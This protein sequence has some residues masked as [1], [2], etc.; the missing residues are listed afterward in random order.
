MTKDFRVLLYYKYEHIEDPE[1]F[2]KEHLEFSKSIGLRGRVLVSNEGING[3]VSGTVEQTEKYKEYLHSLPGFE[4]V[5]F[6]EDIVDDYAH[7]KMHVRPRTEIV[8]LNLEDD[9]NPDEITGTYLKP[10]EFKEAILDEDTVVLDTRNDYEYD[11]GHFKGAVRPEI[12]NFRDLPQWIIENK[13]KFMDKKV[14]VYCTGGVR[15][16]KLSG[17]MLREGLADE[18]G[19]LEGGIDT[20]AKDSET[21]GELW[22]GKMYVFDDRISVPINQVNPTVISKDMF[23]GQPCDRYVNCGN[24]ECNKQVFMSEENEKKYLRGCTV[25]CRRHPRNRYIKEHNLSKK[26]WEERLNAINESLYVTEN[27]I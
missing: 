16:E 2:S 27:T 20:Y 17:W 22:D 8:S 15:C 1:V 14:A 6:K 25:K 12:R 19:Q 18:V 4:D 7:R 5:W 24:P 26:V 23:D 11:L 9:I 3:T 21:L 13:E 10:K